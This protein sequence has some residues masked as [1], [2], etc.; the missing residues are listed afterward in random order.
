[1]IN[2]ESMKTMKKY[3][4]YLAFASSLTYILASCGSGNQSQETE[5]IEEEVIVE[6]TEPLFS[7][8][9]DQGVYFE[10]LTD[11]QEVSSPVHVVMGVR[12][13]KV[14]PANEYKEGFGHHHIIIDGGS[15][16]MGQ[17]VPRMKKIST[18]AMAVQKQTWNWLQ[19]PIP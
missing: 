17:I 7:L 11:G 14:E 8:T 15:I 5:V 10:N 6:S 2:Q 13:M 16:E 1:M 9:D 12:G 19:G 4:F 18:T 3:L